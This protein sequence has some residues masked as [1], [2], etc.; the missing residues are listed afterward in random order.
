MQRRGCGIPM[1]EAPTERG[2]IF[3]LESKTLRLSDMQGKTNWFG[4]MVIFTGV[5][6]SGVSLIAI[7]ARTEKQDRSSTQGLPQH[8]SHPDKTLSCENKGGADNTWKCHSLGKKNSETSTWPV[9]S[10][11]GQRRTQQ[12]AWVFTLHFLLGPTLRSCAGLNWTLIRDELILKLH[13]L[14]SRRCANH[15]GECGWILMGKKQQ[16]SH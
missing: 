16:R 15:R 2:T 5:Y 1:T 10:D 13:K 12:M 7:S 4:I 6:F 8:L 9:W 3:V 14:H 11:M